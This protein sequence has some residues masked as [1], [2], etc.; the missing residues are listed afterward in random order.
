MPLSINRVKCTVC[1]KT[2]GLL[3]ANIVPYSQVPLH[4]QVAI[5]SDAS[6]PAGA[7]TMESNPAIDENNVKYIIRQYH[8]HWR[9]RTITENISLQ[10]LDLLIRQCFSHF[11]RQLQI[12]V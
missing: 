5:I 9:Q 2:H 10:P 12:S 11:D 1:E 3:L 4:D 8:H 7:A 6:T